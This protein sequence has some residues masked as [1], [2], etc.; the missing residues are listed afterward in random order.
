MR[1]NEN[2]RTDIGQPDERH[3]EVYFLIG[4]HLWESN[5]NFWVI[6]AIKNIRKSLW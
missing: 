6:T 5:E 4:Q 3:K 2:K 1:K